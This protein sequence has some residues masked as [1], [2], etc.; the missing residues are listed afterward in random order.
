MRGSWKTGSSTSR[1]KG[2]RKG[3]SSTPIL[4]NIFLHHVVDRWFEEEVRPRLSGEATLVRF[5]GHFVMT[6]ETHHDAR[7]ML[8]VLGKRLGRQGLTLHPDKTCFIGFRPQRR[9]GDPFC[10]RADRTHG[11]VPNPSA[12]GGKHPRLPGRS[13]PLYLPL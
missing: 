2:L 8:E 12:S 1:P 3:A 10:P 5:A 13:C 9:G 6:F 7:R 11:L 4:S